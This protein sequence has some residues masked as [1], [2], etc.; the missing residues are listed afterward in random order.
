MFFSSGFL[1]PCFGRD[2][3]NFLSGS[4]YSVMFWVQYEKNVDNTDV[5]S[6][7]KVVLI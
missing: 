2:R 7:C 6:V 5:F 4:W 3:V 1:C